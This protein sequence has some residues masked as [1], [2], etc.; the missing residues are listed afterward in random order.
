MYKD[1]W[2]EKIFTHEHGISANALSGA[3]GSTF[4]T[5]TVPLASDDDRAQALEQR[6]RRVEMELRKYKVKVWLYYLTYW[7]LFVLST[8]HRHHLG[9]LRGHRHPHVLSSCCSVNAF[10]LVY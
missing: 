8:N 4:V 1:P 9:G 10:I 3:G 2:G 5:S 7:G 6:L